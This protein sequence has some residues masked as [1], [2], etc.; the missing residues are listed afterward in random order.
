MIHERLVRTG[1]NRFELTVDCY[2]GGNPVLLFED[3]ECERLFN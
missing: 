1:E 2:L 3:A